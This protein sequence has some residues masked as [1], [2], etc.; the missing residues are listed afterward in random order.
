MA[1]FMQS[2]KVDDRDR[3]DASWLKSIVAGQLVA[4]ALWPALVATA[5]STVTG[6]GAWIRL[7]LS[8]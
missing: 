1:G 5:V 8:F 4:L 7:T 6:T 3:P 2:E